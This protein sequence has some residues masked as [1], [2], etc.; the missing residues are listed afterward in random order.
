MMGPNYERPDMDVPA[1]FRNANGSSDESLA[2]LPWWKVFKD[3]TLQSLISDALQNNK[4]L[5]AA[6][7]RAEQAYET[8][9]IT[10]APLF[11]NVGYQAGVSHGK[12]STLGNPAST[13]G[14]IVSPVSFGASASWYL[15]FWGKVRRQ[16]EAATASYLATEEA[17][18]ALML[19]LVGQVATYYL[20]LIEIDQELEITKKTVAS[21]EESLKLFQAQLAG[22]L[23]DVLQVSSAEAAL[24]SAAAQIPVLETKRAQIE[25]AICLLTGRGPGSINRSG[26]FDL[27][28]QSVNIPAGIPSALLNRRPDIRQAEQRLRASNAQVGVAIANYFPSISLTSNI[29]TV[30]ADLTSL[31]AKTNSSWGIG[32]NLTGPL[33][34]AGALTASERQAKSAFME[35]KAGYEQSVLTALGEVANALVERQKLV[36]VIKQREA[37]VTAYQTAVTA[38]RD[39]FRTGLSSYYEVL[40]AQQNLFPVEVALAQSRLAYAQT[41]VKLYLALGGGWNYDNVSFTKGQNQ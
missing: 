11:P 26:S 13:N 18:R 17:R 15:D 32:A 23:G 5:N 14:K 9:T 19:S 16:S 35:A 8:I 28:S 37:S 1:A 27:V 3:K 21:F 31:N 24:A 29:G 7:A 41:V 30:S 2:D 34:Q 4:D 33:F 10:E 38:S 12:N 6:I 22:G 39:R 25:N 40:T 20:Q 36:D